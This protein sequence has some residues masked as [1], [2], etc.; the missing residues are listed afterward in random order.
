MRDMFAEHLRLQQRVMD[1]LNPIVRDQ[2]A[3]EAGAE[4]AMR[5]RCVRMVRPCDGGPIS[6]RT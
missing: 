1:A 2:A 3:I 4:A 5:L 6:M